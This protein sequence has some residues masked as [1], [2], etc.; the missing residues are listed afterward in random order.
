MYSISLCF[1]TSHEVVHSVPNLSSRRFGFIDLRTREVALTELKHHVRTTWAH[2]RFMGALF[3]E[4]V[5]VHTLGRPG[6]R[7]ELAKNDE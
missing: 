3:L 1:L 6:D 7:K 4:S 5:S 2:V